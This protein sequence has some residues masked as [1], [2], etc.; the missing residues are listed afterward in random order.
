MNAGA[1][2]LIAAG[3]LLRAL[4]GCQGKRVVRL[5]EGFV[6]FK[7]SGDR[8]KTK[9]DRLA[10]HKKDVSKLKNAVW[11]PDE[12]EIFGSAKLL[13][14]PKNHRIESAFPFFSKCLIPSVIRVNPAH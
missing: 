4:D 3:Y 13:Q 6:S 11:N 12:A 14:D 9:A 7:S 1:T 5:F 8:P 2:T 10:A